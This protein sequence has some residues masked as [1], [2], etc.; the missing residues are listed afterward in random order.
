MAMIVVFR[1]YGNSWHSMTE[2]FFSVEVYKTFVIKEFPRNLY[3]ASPLTI[4]DI[5]S[6]DEGFLSNGS[7]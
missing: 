5:S 4:I 7:F 3:S 6:R 2:Q 1:T